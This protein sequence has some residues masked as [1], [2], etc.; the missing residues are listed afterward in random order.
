[1]GTNGE[2]IS[3][4]IMGMG[5]YYFLVIIV[6]STSFI[7]S[8]VKWYSYTNK[9]NLEKQNRIIVS[10]LFYII[11][12]LGYGLASMFFMFPFIIPGPFCYGDLPFLILGTG[13]VMLIANMHIK[14]MGSYLQINDE[15]I[16]Y[17]YGNAIEVIKRTNIRV[18][19]LY[20]GYIFITL[21]ENDKELLI[22]NYFFVGGANVSTW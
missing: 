14:C 12:S 6:V 11:I 8:F 4:N 21:K 2:L 7:F 20:R 18:A 1:M 19:Y 3:E 22:P 9:K 17:K 10:P 15:F 16:Y 13:S 5:S